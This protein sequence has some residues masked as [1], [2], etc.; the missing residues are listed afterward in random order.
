MPP[1]TVL[2]EM[3]IFL[4]KKKTVLWR[5]YDMFGV[6][7]R[8]SGNRLAI[9]GEYSGTAGNNSNRV[10]DPYH[11]VNTYRFNKLLVSMCYFIGK[12]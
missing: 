2:K 7:S 11:C 8:A 4:R 5:R 6:S 3:I 1:P 12:K 10:V 9:L